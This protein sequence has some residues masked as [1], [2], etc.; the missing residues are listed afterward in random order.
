[1][2]VYLRESGNRGLRS[3]TKSLLSPY[4]HRTQQTHTLIW[5]GKHNVYAPVCTPMCVSV[6][7]CAYLGGAGE[8]ISWQR[9]VLCHIQGA[10]HYYRVN[11]Q[12]SPSSGRIK[13]PVNNFVK[14][15][16]PFTLKQAL[17]MVITNIRK[18]S[19]RE[20]PERESSWREQRSMLSQKITGSC[21][22]LSGTHW[23]VESKRMNKLNGAFTVQLYRSR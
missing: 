9:W 18:A 17:N 13:R 14:W 15:N 11:L 19:R 8:T 20:P 4:S 12:I 21:L 5:Q 3:S 2:S 6:Y 7:V 16:A 1:M 22:A 23:K 10:R